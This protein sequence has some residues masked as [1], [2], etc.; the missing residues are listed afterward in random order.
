MPRGRCIEIRL[1]PVGMECKFLPHGRRCLDSSPEV[2][3]R[4]SGLAVCRSSGLCGKFPVAT[5]ALRR[6][7]LCEVGLRRSG[8]ACGEFFTAIQSV[9]RFLQS[10]H[11]FP[12][13]RNFFLQE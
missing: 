4:R 11:R 3:L 6:S 7:F 2:R 9:R 13:H 1:D 12:P 5:L 8:L 10:V